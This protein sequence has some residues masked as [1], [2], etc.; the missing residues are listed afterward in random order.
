MVRGR[1]RANNTVCVCVCR[2]LC[3]CVGM[4]VCVSNMQHLSYDGFM[5]GRGYV[6]HSFGQGLSL[7]TC[8]E[9]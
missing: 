8:S 6:M 7:N 5:M 2:L 1:R 3:V 9:I 4:W